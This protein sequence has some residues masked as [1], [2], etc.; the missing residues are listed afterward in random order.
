MRRKQFTVD[1]AI[2]KIAADS[3]SE[4]DIISEDDGWPSSDIEH[5]CLV[6][7]MSVLATEVDC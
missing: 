5:I 1:E 3:D 4:H 6:V 7:R 2:S